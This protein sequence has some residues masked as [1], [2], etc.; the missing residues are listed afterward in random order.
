M[1]QGRRLKALQK[2]YEVLAARLS[3]PGLV[4]HGTIT[5]RTIISDDPQRPG[6]KKRR[7]PYYQWTRKV[8]GRTVT[9]N[10][11]PSQVGHFERAIK[12]QRRIAQILDEMVHISLKILE[13]TT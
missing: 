5:P 9:V 2:R 7:G 4:L 10:L 13:L 3:K 6:H 12:N 1:T 11:S 8:K